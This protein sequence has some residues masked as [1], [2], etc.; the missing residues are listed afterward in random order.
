MSADVETLATFATHSPGQRDEAQPLPLL[1]KGAALGRYLVL[2]RLGMGG[3]GVVYAAWDPQLDRKVAIK[4]VRPARRGGSLG[5]GRM[6]LLRE[7]QAMAKLSHP[8]VV[9]VHDAGTVDEQVFVAMEFIDGQ[10]LRAWLE[11]ATRG[12]SEVLEH[13]RQ[14]GRGL[15]AAHAQDLIHRDFKPDNV[16]IGSDGRVVVMDFGL[17]RARSNPN[18]SDPVAKPER[19]ATTE[20]MS[21]DIRDTGDVSDTGDQWSGALDSH[22]TEV[23]KLLGTPAYMAPEQ[24]GGGEADARSD[25][26][27]FCVALYEALYGERPFVGKSIVHLATAILEGTISPEPRASPVPRWLRAVV[28][29]GLASDPAQRFASMD[30][31]L[32]ALARDPSQRRR[33]RM[34]VAAAGTLALLAA[35]IGWLVWLVIE[36]RREQAYAT[37]D[38]AGREIDE[39]WND[40]TRTALERSLGGTGSPLAAT[41][42]MYMRAWLDPWT[43]RW[44]SERTATCVRGEIDETL[45]TTLYTQ[46]IACFDEQRERLA[47]MLDVFAL[48]DTRMVAGA[49]KAA[50]AF[51][52]LESCADERAL[53]RRP[54]LPTTLVGSPLLVDFRRRLARAAALADAG[55]YSSAQRIADEALAIAHSLDF[56]PLEAEALLV[57][58]AIDSEIGNYTQVHEELRRAFGL[59]SASGSDPLAA[60]AAILLLRVLGYHLA[61]S[62]E[63]LA[64]A[65]VATAL[66]ERLGLDES[67]D[68][69]QLA[70]NTA[71][72]HELLG[73]YEETERWHRRALELRTKLLGSEHPETG[74]SYANLG[75]LALL[76]DDHDA[77]LEWHQRALDVRERGLGPSHPD[78]GRSHGN[79]GRVY[80]ARGQLDEALAHFHESHAIFS[81][82]IGAEHRVAARV[83]DSIADVHRRRGELDEALAQYRRALEIQVP[84][85][86][87]K[88]PEAALSNIGI[89]RVLLAQGQLQEAFRH[90]E[91]A[92]IAYA[93]LGA[94]HPSN[95][96]VRELMGELCG[97]GLGGA[98]EVVVDE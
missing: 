12:W 85:L 58:A 68:A 56:K 71:L 25:Q 5:G 11:A 2:E 38:A 78:V 39:V 91:A 33:T 84:L 3:M 53:A 18:E 48:S 57:Q 75:N 73:D 32:E 4:L 35:S 79:I 81:R 7:A 19:D 54:E 83:H 13:F 37:C 88:H 87:E 93:G 62:G 70:N 29:R 17:V 90:V 59:A 46:S 20:S 77:A 49:G 51:S 22:L 72:V 23:G 41:S 15:A 43:V 67:L 63:G 97:A 14:A 44:T 60:K 64:W 96:E 47:A 65:D 9:A 21:G 26:F 42:F 80:L 8:N 95:V 76:R 61:R 50:A 24:L 92:A 89:A 69:A 94:G 16:M 66:L 28:V 45:S 36:H 30:E 10:S 1:E 40:E 86:G 55:D 98:C 82:T 27:G 74:H 52:Q 6:R 34:L 31:L